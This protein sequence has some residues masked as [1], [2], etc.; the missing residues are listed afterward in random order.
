MLRCPYRSMLHLSFV[1]NLSNVFDVLETCVTADASADQANENNPDPRPE[2]KR[3]RITPKQFEPEL[4]SVPT[5]PGGRNYVP[6]E[7]MDHAPVA[8]PPPEVFAAMTSFPSVFN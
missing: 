5:N 3:A 8:A 1:E 2:P 4:L 6:I 7:Y